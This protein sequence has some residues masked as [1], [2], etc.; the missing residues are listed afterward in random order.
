MEHTTQARVEINGIGVFH[1]DCRTSRRSSNGLREAWLE[2]FNIPAAEIQIA[3]VAF[4]K[5]DVVCRVECVKSGRLL[6][7]FSALVKKINGNHLSLCFA[8]APE[9]LD[10]SL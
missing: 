8:G 4:E 10:P 1:A 2:C 7:N 5:G 6:A 3:N 9:F